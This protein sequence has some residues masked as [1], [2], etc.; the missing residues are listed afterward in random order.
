MKEVS[1]IVNIVKNLTLKYKI[2]KYKKI[3]NTKIQKKEKFEMCLKT[4]I[5]RKLFFKHLFSLI[6]F[7]A[8][9]RE[10]CSR[11]ILDFQES[12]RNLEKVYRTTRKW[13]IHCKT[14]QDK[15]QF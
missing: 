14:V 11:E 10:I 8:S 15:A 4:A 9:I 5:V 13:Y 3:Q 12:F 6:N 2:Q 7:K 1:S